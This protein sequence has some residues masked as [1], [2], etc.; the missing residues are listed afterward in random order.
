MPRYVAHFDETDHMDGRM[1]G[2]GGFCTTG[3]RLLGLVETW[4][5]MRADLEMEDREI[6]SNNLTWYR[7]DGLAAWVSVMPPAGIRLRRSLQ[8]LDMPTRTSRGR[9]CCV[10]AFPIP[11][12]LRSVKPANAPLWLS[13]TT[14]CPASAPRRTGKLREVI[15]ALG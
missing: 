4:Q 12:E 9:T 13:V 7:R 11:R 8:A 15:R 10:D 1:L 6:K 14:I 2:F 5:E 3:G